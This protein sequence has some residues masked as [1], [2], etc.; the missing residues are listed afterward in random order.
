MLRVWLQRFGSCYP[1]F[2]DRELEIGVTFCLDLALFWLALRTLT[3]W[4]AL[5][6]M[7]EILTLWELR[8]I[9]CYG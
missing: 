2:S 4:A 1:W 8:G 7:I 3:L 9:P 6:V 5:K